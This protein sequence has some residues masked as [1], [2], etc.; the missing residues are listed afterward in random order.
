MLRILMASCMFL[1][2]TAGTAAAHEADKFMRVFCAGSADEIAEC[3]AEM[4]KFRKL[5]KRAFENDY[6]AQRNLAYTL[7]KGNSVVL[8]D[9]KTSCAWRVAI[10]WLG[11]SKVDTSDRGNMN[12]YCG[13]LFPDQ[14]PEALE[15]GKVIG[16]RVLA[17]GKIDETVVVHKPDPTLDGTAEPLTAD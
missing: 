3:E 12:T 5:Y 13:M 11:S 7:W 10:I 2:V 1:A 4:A 14:R 8:S 17:G 9:R 6:Q 15:L 16:R